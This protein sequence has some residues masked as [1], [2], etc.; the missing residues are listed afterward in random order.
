[1][2]VELHPD[3]VH[4]K[5]SEFFNKMNC[6]K[7]QYCFMTTIEGHILRRLSCER[8]HFDG[9]NEEIFSGSQKVVVVC[10]TVLGAAVVKVT[11]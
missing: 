11:I 1:M 6:D 4:S 7:I 10:E 3:L 5:R 8:E 9:L 2:S